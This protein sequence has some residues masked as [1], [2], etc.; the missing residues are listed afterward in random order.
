MTSIVLIGFGLVFLFLSGLWL[1]IPALYSLPWVPTREKRIHKALQLAKLQPDE[2]LYDLG[3]GDGR[4]L[5]MAAEEFG[6]RAVGIEIGPV[7]CLV[8]WL[9]ILFTGDR[10]RRGSRHTAQM[11]CGNFYKADLREAEVVFVYATSKQMSRLQEK[12]A[13]ELRPG[14]RVVSISANFPDWQPELVDREMLIFL[15]SMPPVRA[16]EPFPN[17]VQ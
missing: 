12:L 5:L 17:E 14:A 1:L 6:A 4:V 11:R 15:Y 13:Q 2:V 3:A 9:R 10:P 8:G 7:Q 16:V